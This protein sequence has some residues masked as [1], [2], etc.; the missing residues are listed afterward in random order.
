[1]DE[2]QKEFATSLGFQAIHNRVIGFSYNIGRI[3]EMN[4]Q[5]NKLWIQHYGKL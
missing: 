1:M 2:L 3:H 5:F 4:L